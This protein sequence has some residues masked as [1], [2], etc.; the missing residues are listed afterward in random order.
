[1]K[2]ELDEARRLTGP[3]LLWEYPG[4]IVDVLIEN[5]D[6]E[7]VALCWQKWVT[8][9]LNEFSWS[10]EQSTYRL[11]QEG[12]NLAI[13][14]PMDALYTAC[15]LAE[16]AWHCCAAELK[17]EPAFDWRSR[18]GE[19]Q[20]VLAEERNPQL[21]EF[22]AKAEHNKVTCLV[23]D[24]ELSLGMGCHAETWPVTKLPS[25]DEL[26]WGA[27]RDIPSALIT[28]TNGKS[29]SVR[30][31]SEIASMN[32]MSAGVTSTDF[33]RV[34]DV[35]IDRGDYSGPGGARMLLRDRR[36]EIAFL[37]VARGGILRR[38]LPVEKVDAAVVTNI[39]SDHLGQYG[40][41][42]VEQLAEAKFVVSKAL[43]D[44]GVLVVN[45]DDPL[46]ISQAEKLD[47]QL[48]WFSLSETNELVQRQKQGSGRAVYLSGDTI[49]YCANGVNEAICE[50]DE[51]AMTFGGTAKHNIQNAM[52]V[53]GLSMALKLPL[54]SIRKG[55]KSFGS[56]AEDNPGRGN[57]YSID[58]VKVIVDFAHNEHSMRAV[59]DMVRQM[60]ADNR[61][62]MFSHAGD[63]SDQDIQDLTEAVSDVNAKYY[64][65]AELEHHLRGR[66]LGDIPKI[67]KAHL[68]QLGILDERI[69]SAVDP[70][71]GAKLA[72]ELARP[73]DVVLLFVLDQ[74]EQ[75]HNWLSRQGN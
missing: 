9:C 17:Q 36:T 21:I 68:H 19:L 30:L 70:L 22:I 20:D 50:I 42:T 67:I 7:L 29:T 56:T 23:D 8:K 12:A 49:M 44:D 61:I 55:L 52:G 65:S 63:R 43:S 75:V 51:V 35:I 45:A 10:H 4:A 59:V 37:E 6:G 40:I 25:P 41:H 26:D 58:G 73:G 14:A 38:G 46:V 15:E 33:I 39:A 24:D 3:N 18:L 16:L 2:L 47:V 5:V 34:G 69:K 11:H 66:E 28:G 53:V 1:M 62:A 71:E 54:E 64:I 32:E 27:Y 57:M 74:R 48:C 60:P 31:A 13:S 72:L